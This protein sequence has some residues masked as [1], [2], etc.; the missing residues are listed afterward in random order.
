M[1]NFEKLSAINVGEHI[2]KKNGL[3]YLSWAWAVDQLMRHDPDAN[4][5]MNEPTVYPDGTMMVSCVVT[6]FGKPVYM[7]LPVM[8]HRNR[9]IPQPNAFDINKNMMRCLVKAIAC[10]GLGLYVYAGEDLPEEAKKE[11]SE[12]I[13]KEIKTSDLEQLKA[14]WK[15]LSEEERS[16]NQEAFSAR[17]KELEAA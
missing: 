6:A 2:E 5:H 13:A 12:K 16:A 14:M 4:W 9:A 1:N 15:K 11:A 8:D 3:S 7:W 10:H 17:R